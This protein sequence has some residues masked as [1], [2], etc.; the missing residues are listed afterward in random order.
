M[1]LRILHA[2][3]VTAILCGGAVLAASALSLALG[4]RPCRYR[5]EVRRRGSR[6]W[7]LWCDYARRP[8]A[9]HVARQVCS[10]VTPYD[11][12]RIRRVRP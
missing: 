12:Y 3:A 2:L 6:R 10:G 9:R 8:S 1:T 11:R 5:V 7:L 4:P